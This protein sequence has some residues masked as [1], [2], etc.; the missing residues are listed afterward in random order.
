MRIGFVG[1]G[2]G[3]HFYPLIA[4]AEELQ[5]RTPTP[6][7]YYFGPSPYNKDLLTQMNITYIACPAGKLRRYFS[8]QNF[9]DV[10]KSFFGI[11]I[12]IWKLYVI[13][14]DVIFSKGGFTSVPILLAARFLRIPVVIHESDAVPG[15]ANN[16]A[17]KFAR[18]IGIA[19]DD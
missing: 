13:Y 4:V 12:A 15:R 19:Y 1:G 17:K 18:Y 8:V 16:L 10:F 9:I 14:P 11:F 5:A 2:T 6:E 7:L 3:G